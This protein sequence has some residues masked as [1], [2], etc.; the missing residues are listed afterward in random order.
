MR[1]VQRSGHTEHTEAPAMSGCG[2]SAYVG[3][4]DALEEVV[5][6]VDIYSLDYNKTS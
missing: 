1:P 3:P 6:D 5:S 2:T 4:A